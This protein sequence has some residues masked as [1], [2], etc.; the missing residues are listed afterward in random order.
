MT[1][2]EPEWKTPLSLGR[3]GGGSSRRL[4][5]RLALIGLA[6]VLGYFSVIARI[7]GHPV[8][9]RWGFPQT[10][11]LGVYLLH[12]FPLLLLALAGAWLV[13][14]A[15]SDDPATLGVIL[16][17]ALVFR[18]LLLPTPPLLSSDIF[19]YV[20]DAR[21]QAA[22]VNPYLS[23]PADFDN[24]EARKDPLY[25]QQNRPFARTIYPPLAQA[26]FR[27]V[28]A[29]AGE[30]VNAMKGVML[31]GELATLAILMVLLKSLG[32]PRTRII[33]YAWHPL[34]VFEI[35]GSGHVDAL[36]VPFILLAILAWRR[37]RNAAAGV[38]L[39][40]ATLVKIFPILLL[41]AL[42]GRRRWPLLLACVATI[43]VAY[44][45]FLP[46]AGLK[47]LGHLPHFL[48]DRGETFNPS[49]M[50]IAS[51]LFGQISQAP[52]YWASWVGGG[53]MAA[54]ILWLLR[55]E[56]VSVD[57]LLARIW[58]VATAVT[59]LTLTV[60]PWYLLWLLPLLTIQPRPAW[61]YLTGAISVSYIFYVASPPAR[62]L[63]GVL[64]YL[65]FVLLLGW[66]WRCSET[67][68]LPAAHLG[69][70]REIP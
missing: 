30:R 4:R 51:L 11:F 57:A 64:E 35:A 47:V 65:P 27:A 22:G 6:S 60:H 10:D 15:D 16:G 70:A 37:G 2:H 50:A 67:R 8:F 63:I 56:A 46:A 34:T 32:L 40:A 44:L 24:E 38:A 12:F 53:A 33:L 5:L 1:L 23:R 20:W 26:A 45:P 3:R 18:L 59:L 42:L 13:F 14:R 48:S 66:Q 49:L 55:T 25:Q 29:V 36:A 19:R 69:F 61:L 17:F 28:R 31:L 58:L 62:I 9:L 7:T 39:G 21:I 54:T 41:P 52:Q 43:G 68:A